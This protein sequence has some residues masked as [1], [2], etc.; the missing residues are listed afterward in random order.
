MELTPY[1]L[2][3]EPPTT[4]AVEAFIRVRVTEGVGPTGY[5][6]V[7]LPSGTQLVVRG[8]DL[9]RVDIEASASE[10]SC[11]SVTA[12]RAARSRSVTGGLT[13]P[14]NQKGRSS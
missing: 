11:R 5:I 4:N 1:F 6:A 3:G 13:P 7:Y 10:G 2:C 14:A 8:R 12:R 9:L